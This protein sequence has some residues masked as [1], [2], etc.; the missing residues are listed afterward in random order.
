MVNVLPFSLRLVSPL[1]PKKEEIALDWYVRER[2]EKDREAWMASHEGKERGFPAMVARSCK[3][4]AAHVSN[5][6]DGSK[7]AGA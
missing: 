5:F 6:F 2:L 1:N 3:V 7:K 4:S